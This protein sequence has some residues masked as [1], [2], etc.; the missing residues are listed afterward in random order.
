[1]IQK[2][3]F[4][5]LVLFGFQMKAQSDLPE[6]SSDEIIVD[7]YSHSDIVTNFGINNKSV[8]KAKFFKHSN[9]SKL[10]SIIKT[11]IVNTKSQVDGA[12]MKLH[13]YKVNFDGSPGIEI[14]N[15][16]IFACKKGRNDTAIDVEFNAISI[17]EN[18]IFIGFEWLIIDENSINSNETILG[19]NVSTESVVE[20]K[21]SEMVLK[22]SPLI[23]VIPLRKSNIW[24]FKD[25]EWI[26]SSKDNKKYILGSN[27]NPFY[28]KYYGIAVSLI[29]TK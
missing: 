3:C 28:N 11:V 26:S 24:D 4:M 22:Y 21:K 8:T 14:I 12:K 19:K 17:P 10:N 25:G 6:I 27:L 7:K 23:G 18:G 29:L 1:M 13:F 16:L 2:I 5:L 20:G 15:P 9:K